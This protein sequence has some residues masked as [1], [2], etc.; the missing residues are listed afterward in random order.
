MANQ[1]RYN[2]Q[3]LKNI[4][5]FFYKIN[6]NLC[7]VN[8]FGWVLTSFIANHMN[9]NLYKGKPESR[10]VNYSKNVFFLTVFSF[11]VSYIVLFI[12]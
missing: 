4:K 12:I 6:S 5:S 9:F 11:Y 10:Y 2:N 8:I 1:L 7:M 3:Y